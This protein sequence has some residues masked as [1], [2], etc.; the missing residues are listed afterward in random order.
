M[1]VFRGV[2]GRFL[3]F[4]LKMIMRAV[5]CILNLRD[6]SIEDFIFQFNPSPFSYILFLSP[7]HCR[8]CRSHPDYLTCSVEMLQL[9]NKLQPGHTRARLDGKLS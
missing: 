2:G 1:A 7:G 4:Q 5:I 6:F 9:I 3:H 8:P